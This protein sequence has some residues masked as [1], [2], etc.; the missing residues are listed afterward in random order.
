[1]SIVKSVPN[2]IS[3]RH[4]FFQNFSQSLDICFELFS[5]GE[6]IYSEIVD[7]R[8]PPVRR[9]AR[10]HAVAAWLPRAV[11]LDRTHRTSRQHASR[12]A[13]RVAAVADSAASATALL[14]LRR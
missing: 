5:F 2:L 4:E 12:P 6:I 1:V 13:L 14:S 10:Q 9:R 11:S 3:Y 7:E 8:T